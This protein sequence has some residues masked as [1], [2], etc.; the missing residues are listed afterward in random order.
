M[1]VRYFGDSSLLVETEDATVAQGLRAELLAEAIP[2]LRELVPGFRSL[3]VTADPLVTDLEALAQ[4]LQRRGPP[5]FSLPV[6]RQHEFTVSYD[7]EDLAPLAR[8]LGMEADDLI[9]RHTAPIYTVAFLGFAPGFPY[10]TGLD[11]A[12]HAPRRASPRLRVPAGSVAIADEFCG[13]YPQATPGG[14]QLLGHTQAPLFDP[15]REHPALLAPGDRV[16]FRA[17]R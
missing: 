3:L 9:R 4:R 1:K 11:P 15:G 6:P 14:W 5:K 7:G 10:L 12:L 2:G 8:R 17:V 16:R 13:I